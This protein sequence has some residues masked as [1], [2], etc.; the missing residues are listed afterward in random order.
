M[1]LLMQRLLPLVVTLLL[2]GCFGQAGNGRAPATS[3]TP[4][5]CNGGEIATLVKVV[6]GD[7]I[8][9]E[10]SNGD[11]ERI[12]LIGIDTP[13]RGESCFAEAKQRLTDLLGDGRVRLIKDRSNRDRYGRLLRYVCSDR[14]VFV[15][16]S[17]VREGLA[18]AYR[19]P[20]DTY[21]ADY[22]QELGAEA[23]LERSG[24]L[25]REAMRDSDAG[26]SRC[27][28]VCRRGKACGD[29]CV[30]ADVTCRLPVGCACEG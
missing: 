8:D 6:D 26:D 28:L 7:T 24:C 9:I 10:R 20:P 23:V 18:V 11:T 21:Y 14:D 12:R 17:L 3:V 2:S 22:L 29:A 15:E 25:Y 1:G 5:I 16:G 27:C 30:P 19:Y 4:L 13:E